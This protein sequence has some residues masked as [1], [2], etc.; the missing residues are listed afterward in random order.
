MKVQ[1]LAPLVA[2]L[3][4]IAAGTTTALVTGVPSDG[5]PDKTTITDPLALGIPLVRYECTGEGLLVL[6]FGDTSGALREAKA[7]HDDLD[8]SYLETAESCDT[9]FGPERLTTKPTYAVVAGPYPADLEQPCAMRMT[10]EYRGDFVTALRDG[11]EISVKCV[12][13]LDASVAPELQPGMTAT[14]LDM[15]WIRSLQQILVDR[16]KLSNDP[17]TGVYDQRTEAAIRDYQSSSTRTVDGVV[18]TDTWELVK[19]RTCRHYD[20]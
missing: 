16:G 10:P 7:G 9:N 14:D 8:L 15:V 18:D 11:N 13:V 12:C 19:R 4:G 5:D 6:G 17:V 3:V 20:F 2:A 1:V